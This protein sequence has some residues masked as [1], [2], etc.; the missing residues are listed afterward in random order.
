MNPTPSV[1]PKR[2]SRAWATLRALLRARI[3]A[4]L[5]IILPIWITYLLIKFLFELM[6]DT[7]LW[8]VETWL[9][10]G[11]GGVW[12]AR[13][14]I[15]TEVLQQKGLL[16]F[17]R[18]VQWMIEIFCVFLTIFFIYCVGVLTA[19]FIG[20][21][22]IAAF[23]VLLGRVPLVKTVYK[24]TKQI[25]ASLAGEA[26]QNFQRVAL[27]PFPTKETRSVGF[28]TGITRDERTGEEICAVFIASTP[29]P[30]TG[31]VFVLPRKDLI[32]LPDWSVED[33]ISLVMSGGV[34]VPASISMVSGELAK[35]KPIP[36]PVAV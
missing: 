27:I 13:W 36:E 34:I 28:I 18:E 21:R 9:E 35:S 30:T 22:L 32:E 31:F 12:L 29:N 25:L 8:V 5:I 6:R 19:N 14:G 33:A 3:T 16:A 1:A 15:S 2:R 4:G 20:K 7:S 11:L 17:P 24:A 26:G 23:E 10:M